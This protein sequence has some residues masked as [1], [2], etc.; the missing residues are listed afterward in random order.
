MDLLENAPL[1]EAVCEFRVLP[2]SA[3]DVTLPG[4]LYEKLKEAFPNKEAPRPGASIGVL[5]QPLPTM[6]ILSS[7]MLYPVRFRSADSL[8]IVQVDA[9]AVSVHRTP[10]YDGWDAY[11]SR[12]SRVWD[13]YQEI[14]DVSLIDRVGLR[15]I[16]RI[17]VEKSIHLDASAFLTITPGLPAALS[18]RGVSDFFHRYILTY[19]RPRGSL[20]LQSGVQ[21][22]SPNDVGVV[23]D[24]DF[25]FSPQMPQLADMQTSLA[26]AHDVVENA[27]LA[28][29]S[30]P[31]RAKLEGRVHE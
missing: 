5:I 12:I 25:G 19:D 4:V 11:L 22:V 9:L 10:P 29:L 21:I 6:P 31:L 24:L 13:A 28:C 8:D 3:P 17:P 27:F 15:Y 20:I 18:G 2:A 14:V 30:E 16:N 26:S 1:L 23:L 7:P